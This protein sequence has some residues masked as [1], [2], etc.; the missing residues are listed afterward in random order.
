MTIPLEREALV[1]R[2]DGVRKNLARLRNL[3][4][5]HYA[6]IEPLEIYR[7]VQEDL[8]DIEHVLQRVKYVLEHSGEWG[9]TVE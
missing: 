3:L 7:I 9:L 2:I 8:P 4:V 5:H 6:D 1:P